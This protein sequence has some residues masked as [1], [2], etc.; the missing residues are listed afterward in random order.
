VTI[1][2]LHVTLHVVILI[3]F[4]AFIFFYLNLFQLFLG[5]PHFTQYLCS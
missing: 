3:L 5:P 1:T 4:N 2:L